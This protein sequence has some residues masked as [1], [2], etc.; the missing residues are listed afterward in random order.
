MLHLAVWFHLWDSFPEC[1]TDCDRS[2]CDSFPLSAWKVLLVTWLESPSK[3]RPLYFRENVLPF[4]SYSSRPR[5]RWG[6][7]KD[8]TAW[9][10]FLFE[11]GAKFVHVTFNKI[12]FIVLFG[13][14]SNWISGWLELISLSFRTHRTLKLANKLQDYL[15]Y[16][17]RNGN[18]VS[19]LFL[20]QFN[21][22][23][24]RFLNKKYKTC[25]HNV[26][27]S[28]PLGSDDYGSSNRIFDSTMKIQLYSK[29]LWFVSKKIWILT[30]RNSLITLVRPTSWELRFQ[31]VWFILETLEYFG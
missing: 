22:P 29:L 26:Q 3:S 14:V 24:G 20:D 18:V 9:T 28:G 21:C 19:N 25:R 23:F 31:K 13:D 12:T 10:N 8:L 17:S 2:S 6:K 15:F 30:G 1:P 7:D 27:I 16:L 5:W 4:A 11:Q